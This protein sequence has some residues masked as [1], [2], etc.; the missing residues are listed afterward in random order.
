M[1]IPCQ[2]YNRTI[3]PSTKFTEPYS[4]CTSVAF[5]TLVKL[6]VV[7]SANLSLIS[8]YSA[9]WDVVLFCFRNTSTGTKK[10]EKLSTPLSDM[11]D[12]QIHQSLKE[13][14]FD[15]LDMSAIRL[16]RYCATFCFEVG[17]ALL[18]P[19]FFPAVGNTHSPTCVTHASLT[20]L[21][22]EIITVSTA[23]RGT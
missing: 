15:M 21:Y 9:C 23:T 6:K 20:S 19:P 1:K 7:E 5:F 18:D 11:C 17:S 16:Q 14:Q 10:C 13:K 12:A 22:F 4:A 8:V 3:C 2:Y